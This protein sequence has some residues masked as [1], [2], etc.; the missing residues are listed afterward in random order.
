[1]GKF[2]ITKR[3]TGEFQFTLKSNNGLAILSSE[4]YMTKANC[5][6]GIE[7]IKFFSK[8]DAMFERKISSNSR[9]Y[10]N[11]KS[12]S[13]QVIGTSQMYV[14]LFA[15]DKGIAAVISNAHD[16]PVEDRTNN[17]IVPTFSM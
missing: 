13:G 16:A 5:E 9:Y 3:A 7:A 12:E 1:M 4:G 10:F 6:K 17:R 11:L 2:V 15:C 14:N 8:D